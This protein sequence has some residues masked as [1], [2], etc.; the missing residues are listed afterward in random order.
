MK[1]LT[2]SEKQI[3]AVDSY[4]NLQKNHILI[5]IA[6]PNH[7]VELPTTKYRRATLKLEFEDTE[8]VSFDS[9]NIDLAREI[10]DFVDK[11]LDEAEMIVVHDDRGIERSVGVA[12]ALSKILNHRDDEV[13]SRGIPNMLSYIIILDTYF[14]EKHINNW[15]NIFYVREK[16]LQQN[17]DPMTYKIWKMKLEG[18]K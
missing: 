13:Y 4:N 10:L 1:F 5:S 18:N 9:F 15:N 17:L 6:D 3:T 11:N 12:A 8:K 16:A 14:S 2:L 7:K